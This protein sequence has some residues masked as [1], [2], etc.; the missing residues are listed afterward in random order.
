MAPSAGECQPLL[1]STVLYSSSAV[2]LAYLCHSTVLVPPR[3]GSFRSCLALE[4]RC[5]LC[6]GFIVFSDSDLYVK[7]IILEVM[8]R[9][10]R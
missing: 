3:T 6:I 5:V 9:R 1:A 2:L 7:P 10:L 8:Q 4:L